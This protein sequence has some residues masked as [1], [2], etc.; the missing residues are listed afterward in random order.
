MEARNTSRRKRSA[1]NPKGNVVQPS[2]CAIGV[3]NG[4]QIWSVLP[5]SY[6]NTAWHTSDGQWSN[7][8]PF[9][10]SPW[11]RYALVF[12][13]N[14]QEVVPFSVSVRLVSEGIENGAVYGGAVLVGLYVLIIFELVNRTL[15][16]MLSAGVAIGILSFLN[17]VSGRSREMTVSMR[18]KYK[19]QLFT[20]SNNRG[21]GLLA[22]HG[23][24]D[25]AILYDGHGGNILWDGFLR[26][27]GILDV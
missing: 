10:S 13:T 22:W 11:K 8:D 18:R 27:L 9:S 15:A 20:A 4:I 24:T 25:P 5:Q 21:N 23:N 1:G 16:A 17:E 26:L 12:R 3:S 2:G 7:D 14:S 6:V 19:Y